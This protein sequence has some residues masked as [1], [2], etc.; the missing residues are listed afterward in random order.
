KARD[1]LSRKIYYFEPLDLDTSYY[2]TWTSILG[3]GVDYKS[4]C[5][6]GTQGMCTNVGYDRYGRAQLGARATYAL[7]PALSGWVGSTRRGRRRR[8]TPIRV[9]P[10]LT[11]LAPSK[12]TPATSVRRA[13]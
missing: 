11:S 12:A 8:S 1:N 10:V 7:T 9:R 13:A 2:A 6:A 5:S 3:L 4:G